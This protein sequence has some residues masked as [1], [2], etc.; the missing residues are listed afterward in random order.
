MTTSMKNSISNIMVLFCEAEKKCT[1]VD[2][3]S[4]IRRM[5]NE[6]A[7]LKNEQIGGMG[8]GL[9]N[10]FFKILDTAVIVS[11]YVEEYASKALSY[12]LFVEHEDVVTLTMKICDEADNL[13]IEISK[14]S[15]GMK[16]D[17]VLSK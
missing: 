7:N 10:P 11:R 8:I 15:N 2:V 12:R 13:A 17:L 4:I 1:F 14:L 5:N 6:I 9:I 16:K 3:K